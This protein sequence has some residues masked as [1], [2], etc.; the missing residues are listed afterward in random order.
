MDCAQSGYQQQPRTCTSAPPTTRSHPYR[1]P[2]L[3]VP[4]YQTSHQDACELSQRREKLPETYPTPN[5]TLQLLRLH[6]QTTKILP[7]IL[8]F[9]QRHLSVSLEHTRQWRFWPRAAHPSVLFRSDISRSP[10]D[11]R[12]SCRSRPSS[13]LLSSARR[14]N[15]RCGRFWCR[16]KTDGKRRTGEFADIPRR[17]VGRGDRLGLP[18]DL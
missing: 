9:R 1:L 11:R 6:L 15:V 14:C 18:S 4:L 16:A 12:R 5:A 17:R 2:N 3:H 8:N 13:S 7:V 10:H